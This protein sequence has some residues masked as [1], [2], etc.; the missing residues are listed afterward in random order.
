MRLIISVKP[1]T[2]KRGT[3]IHYEVCVWGGLNTVESRSVY[4][5]KIM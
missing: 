4:F 1:Y 2:N 3:S 5:I